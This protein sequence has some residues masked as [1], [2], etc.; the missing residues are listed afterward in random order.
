MATDPDLFRHMSIAEIAATII[1]DEAADM[2]SKAAQAGA[3]CVDCVDTG[4]AR[5]GRFC[6]CRNGIRLAQQSC[7][8]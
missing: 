6:G 4:M 2:R 7:R 1:L 3:R 5:A 8:S